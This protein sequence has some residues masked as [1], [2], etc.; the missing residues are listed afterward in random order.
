MHQIY[1]EAEKCFVPATSRLIA[2]SWG[3]QVVHKLMVAT[4]KQWS[5]WDSHIHCNKLDGLT[6]KQYEE[7]FPK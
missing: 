2:E 3:R 4:P 6:V 5:F 7:S 1:V